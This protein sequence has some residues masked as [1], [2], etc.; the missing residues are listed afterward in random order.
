MKI[1]VLSD[2]HDNIWNL[3]KVLDQIQR[4]VQ[5]MICCGDYCAP[6]IAAMISNLNVPT[7]ACLG[8][9]DGDQ[10][11]IAQMANKNFHLTPLFAEYGKV[12][13]DN[14]K[15]AYCHYPK[16]AEQLAKNHEFDAV[17]YGHTHVA[18]NK[19]VKRVLLLNPGAVCGISAGVILGYEKKHKPASYAIYNTAS[20][21]A[22]II[23]IK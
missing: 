7:Y 14:K 20:N 2:V 11:G 21:T 15:I 9:V 8:N 5:A 6:F 10:A 23:E 12:E 19:K 17:F 3:G 13:L 4:E 16:L 22:R 1:A 18:K